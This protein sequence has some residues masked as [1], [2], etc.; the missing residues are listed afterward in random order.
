MDLQIFIKLVY[1]IIKHLNNMM[2]HFGKDCKHSFGENSSQNE[3]GI[4]YLSIHVLNVCVINLY[5]CCA[6]LK[7]INGMK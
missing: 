7:N 2:L 1:M 4:C 5:L 3:H 6:V